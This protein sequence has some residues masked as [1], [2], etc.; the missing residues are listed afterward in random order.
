MNKLM[1]KDDK[2]FTN[3]RLSKKKWFVKFLR[4][5][6]IQVRLI[7]S[8]LILSV[9][10]LS[11]LAVITMVL[12]S[13]A[14]ESKI[15]AYSIELTKQ[16]SKNTSVALSRIENDSVDIAFSEITQELLSKGGSL[17][18][19]EAMTMQ[20]KLNETLVKRFAALK[21]VTDIQLFSM[22]NTKFIGKGDTNNKFNFQESFLE[23]LFKKAADESGKPVW[24]AI[25]KDDEI[26]N[27]NTVLT[28]NIRGNGNGIV[29]ARQVKSLAEGNEI[30]YLVIRINEKYIQGIFEDMNIGENT[31]VFILAMDGKVVSS[32]NPVIEVAKEYKNTELTELLKKNEIDGGKKSVF[33]KIDNKNTM[34]VHSRIENMDWLAVST[35]PASYLYSESETIKR[36]I[37]LIAFGSIILAVI[38]SYKISDSV[39]HPL[40]ELVELMNETKNGNLMVAIEDQN[41]DEI[42]DVIRSFNDMVENIRDLVSKVHRSAQRVLLSAEKISM[43]SECSANTV[44]QLSASMQ[45]IAFGTTNQAEDASSCFEKMKVLSKEI[46]KVG[47][48]MSSVSGEVEK[49]SILSKDAMESVVLLNNKTLETNKVS[50]GIIEDI[51]SLST[52]MSEIK[53]IVKMIVQIAEQTNLLSLNAAIEAA[54]AGEAGKGFA[55]VADEVK[56][57]AEQSKSASDVIN[58]IIVNIQKKTEI[59][60]SAAN[61]ASVIL[62]DQIK[63]VE[64]TDTAFKTIFESMSGINEYIVSMSKTVKNVLKSNEDMFG[65]IQNISAVSEETAATVEE[66]SASYEEESAHIQ[67][68]LNMADNLEDMAR[69]L[70]EAI[71]RFSIQEK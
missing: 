45:Q 13:N 9:L 63:A 70:D 29:L 57:L 65:S 34:V 28:E 53:K 38:L 71:S 11:V 19:G 17:S 31:D 21:D 23:A 50:E 40:R 41:K 47:D 10:P 3:F 15:S 51:N 58:N 30:G 2:H 44:E 27:K 52:D 4:K 7:S 54:R 32:R 1:A 12:S 42:T 25:N 66:V 18:E 61:T 20:L 67:E 5:Y 16:V 14:I 59:T 69:E 60:V 22:D 36:V 8:F 48:D 6:K 26:E 68:L 39:S 37:L 46:N 33:Y 43:S 62:K 35:I 64:A 24:V 56:K 49:T 55:V